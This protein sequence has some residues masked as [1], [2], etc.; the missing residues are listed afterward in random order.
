M[1]LGGKGNFRGTAILKVQDATGR[2]EAWELEADGAGNFEV[3]IMPPL[4]FPFTA[5][6]TKPGYLG[7]VRRFA[8]EGK[9][10]DAWEIFP[11]D[12]DA[13]GVIDVTDV[14]LVTHFARPA[15]ND[16]ERFSK[17]LTL[18]PR[19]RDVNEYTCDLDGDGAVGAADVKLAV[20]NKGRR[21]R[22]IG[23]P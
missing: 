12:V 8:A 13:D 9:T 20:S 11:G 2:K 1:K 7:E 4:R 17:G 23:F 18:P 21:L 10:G 6:L 16:E 19:F 15:L 22:R 14:A 5:E 3:I